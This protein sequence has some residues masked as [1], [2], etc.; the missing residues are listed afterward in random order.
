MNKEGK[1]QKAEGKMSLSERLQMAAAVAVL[2]LGGCV[3]GFG[4][5]AAIAMLECWLFGGVR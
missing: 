5:G 2:M 3:L 4:L 1:S